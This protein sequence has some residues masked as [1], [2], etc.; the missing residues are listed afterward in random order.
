MA[1]SEAP[2]APQLPGQLSWPRPRSPAMACSPSKLLCHL[3]SGDSPRGLGGRMPGSS[4]SDPGL[5]HSLS[6]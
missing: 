3:T 6:R 1:C 5:L 2:R 4:H